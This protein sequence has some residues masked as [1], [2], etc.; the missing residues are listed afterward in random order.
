MLALS[1]FTI[2]FSQSNDYFR[3]A[4][5]LHVLALIVVLRS[6]L[7]FLPMLIF[8][9]LMIVFFID[10]L[11]NKTPMPKLHKLSYHLNYWLLHEQSGLQHKYD[12]ASIAFDGGVFLLL[13]MTAV[14]SNKTLVIFYDQ[15]TSEQYRRLRFIH[16]SL[17]L[18]PKT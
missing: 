14:H 17:D 10:I 18:R 13:K 8:F 5:V 6:A 2:T 11:R 9:F 3:G 16:Y 7:P 15:I 4:F 1:G 12:N